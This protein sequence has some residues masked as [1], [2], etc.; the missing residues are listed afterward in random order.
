MVQWEGTWRRPSGLEPNGRRAKCV[1]FL[2]TRRVDA[3][4]HTWNKTRTSNIQQPIP[5]HTHDQLS[6]SLSLTHT[7]RVRPH[8]HTASHPWSADSSMLQHS[9][10]MH[11]A[12]LCFHTTFHSMS[13][14]VAT[15]W[16][17]L[18]QITNGSRHRL[19]KL[20]L[21][22]SDAIRDMIFRFPFLLWVARGLKFLDVGAPRT[23]TQSMHAAFDILGYRA[24]H[25]GYH[26]AS[27]PPWCDY[28]FGNGS[29]ETALATV[30]GFDVAMDEP[31]MLVYEE[32]MTSFP[33][34]K[35]ILT[36]SDPESWH[37]NYVSVAQGI[38]AAQEATGL[39]PKEQSEI[40]RLCTEMGSWG[41]DFENPS[42]ASRQTCIQSYKAHNARVQQVIPPHRLLVY[43]W[44]DGW[45]GLSHF[46]QVPVP[47]A[48]FPQ[49]DL[50]ADTFIPGHAEESD[51]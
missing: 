23:G 44:S 10:M 4:V 1:V 40:E 31:M 9:S 6:L 3:Q 36:V 26:Q 13:S 45:A 2:W 34:S 46:L 30:A 11:L 24:L 43:N 51:S 41:C 38:V 14:P 29:L 12:G 39:H 22:S 25:T 28:L 15:V 16:C 7:T 5:T 19:Q 18:A 32:V 21:G 47:D 42:P 49:Q 27:R 37:D 50:V 35:F 33:E 48:E 20:N 17:M 8:E